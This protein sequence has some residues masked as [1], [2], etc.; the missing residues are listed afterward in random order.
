MDR[1][2]DIGHW[3]QQQESDGS[4]WG[5]TKGFTENKVLVL[6]TVHGMEEGPICRMVH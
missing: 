6:E 3:Q 1:R 4:L 5:F 2:E